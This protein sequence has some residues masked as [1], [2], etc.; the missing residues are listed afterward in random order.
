MGMPRARGGAAALSAAAEPPGELRAS[1]A[2]APSSVLAGSL[3]FS[4]L[5]PA[6]S[7]LPPGGRGGAGSGGEEWPCPG[8]MRL[9]RG[10][11]PDAV[12]RFEQPESRRP[13]RAGELGPRASW[14][15]R[16]W[17]SR[18]GRDLHSGTRQA[19]W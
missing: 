18:E 5:P 17:E 7:L 4:I 2:R 15:N 3:A 16:N 14:S 13:N 1:R 12:S 8:R 11:E 10:A 19:L 6:S 9:C